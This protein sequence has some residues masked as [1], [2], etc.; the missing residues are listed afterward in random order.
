MIEKITKK[1]IAYSK[2]NIKD[3]NHFLKVHS[4]ARTIGLMEKIGDT[5]QETLEIAAI[6]HDIACPLCRKK[7]GSANGKLQEKEGGSLAREFLEEFDIDDNIKE[8]V[9]Y[10]VSHHHTYTDVD[11]KD[12]Q[13]LLEADYFVN[14]YEKNLPKENVKNTLK[15]VFK[16]KSGQELLKSIYFCEK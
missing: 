2:G 7:Y 4:F 10:L 14:S 11:G 6:I 8:R 15:K 5:E 12:Y 9:V 1:M 16:T 13:I 3:I